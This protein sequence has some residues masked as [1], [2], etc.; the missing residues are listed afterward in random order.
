MWKAVSVKPESA[1]LL[2]VLLALACTL[3]AGPAD[4]QRGGGGRGWH[5][6]SHSHHGGWHGGSH[7]GGG[8]HHGG[9]WHGSRVA[10]GIGV[11]YGGYWYGGGPYYSYAPYY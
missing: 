2:A 9:H 7:R 10:I 4:A 3:A 8:H 6:G 11:G 5:G 1:A